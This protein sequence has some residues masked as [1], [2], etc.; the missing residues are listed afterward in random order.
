MALDPIND[1]VDASLTAHKL[2]TTEAVPAWK[3]PRASPMSSS[4][5]NTLLSPVSHAESVTREAWSRRLYRSY[6]DSQLSASWIAENSGL[7][8]RNTACEAR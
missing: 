1:A 8:S 5:P 3:N 4:P 2:T 7:S 6:S